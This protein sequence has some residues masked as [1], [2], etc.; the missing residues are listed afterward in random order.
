MW[1]LADPWESINTERATPEQKQKPQTNKFQQTSDLYRDNRTKLETNIFR[2]G[3]VRISSAY[4]TNDTPTPFAARSQSCRIS[5][6]SCK[7][8]D[9]TRCKVLSL[10][11]ACKRMTFAANTRLTG[12]ADI[13]RHL[14]TRRAIKTT[15]I[16]ASGDADP[17]LIQS[18]NK[19]IIAPGLLA[20]HSFKAAAPACK[21]HLL[22]QGSNINPNSTTVTNITR[23]T[24]N[25][26]N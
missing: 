19:C 18:V 13:S 26:R 3:S 6:H 10:L 16:S 17:C 20:H 23:H 22:P 9:T 11:S 5:G 1:K 24:L 12:N 2:V 7:T 8:L 14:K 25:P 4:A 15:I 21:M